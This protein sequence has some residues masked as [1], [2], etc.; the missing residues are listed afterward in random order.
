MLAVNIGSPAA[1]AEPNVDQLA[2]INRYL[3][4]NQVEELRAFL[5]INPDLLEGEGALAALLREF[6]TE[7]SDL[8]TYLGFEPQL[9]DFVRD[10][11]TGGDIVASPR[12]REFEP[13]AGAL[14]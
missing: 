12:D 4:N 9:R 1:A 14:Y 3:E 11:P 8:T 7:S 13:A 10:S 6:M 2:A 5:Q